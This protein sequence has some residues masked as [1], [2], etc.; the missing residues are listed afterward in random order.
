VFALCDKVS[1]LRN[2][3]LVGTRRINELSRAELV[4]MMIGRDE[5]SG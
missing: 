2:G 5:R 1:V 3:R 4:T